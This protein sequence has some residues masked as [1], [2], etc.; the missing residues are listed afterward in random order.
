MPVFQATG[1]AGGRCRMGGLGFGLP[2]SRLYTRYFG[3]DLR[4]VSMPVRPENGFSG[5][6]WRSSPGSGPMVS[7]QRL[8]GVTRVTCFDCGY[9]C[10]FMRELWF[11]FLLAPSETVEV[12]WG[13]RVWGW[14]ARI[15]LVLFNTYAR[16]VWTLF[17]SQG[18]E[19]MSCAGREL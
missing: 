11:P 10:R 1:Q 12:S 16:I 4:L 6:L 17:D 13:T 9:C 8:M 2:L 18:A 7:R 3:G 14:A 5:F 15:R 19:S